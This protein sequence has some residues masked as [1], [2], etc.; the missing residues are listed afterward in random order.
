MYRGPYGRGA[1]A[2]ARSGLVTKPRK[3]IRPAVKRGI[4]GNELR[5]LG[6]EISSV[7]EL[8]DS[9]SHSSCGTDYHKAYVE[10]TVQVELGQQTAQNEQGI[11]EA[12][13][14]SSGK[15]VC[16]CF[17]HGSYGYE[18]D[19]SLIAPEAICFQCDCYVDW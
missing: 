1:S 7:T 3:R 8:S 6:S 4:E 13:E 10:E 16:V 9:V 15:N 12:P 11:L 17:C 5:D 18:A 14:D 2:P 19:M